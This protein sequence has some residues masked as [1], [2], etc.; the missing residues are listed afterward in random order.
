MDKATSNPFLY[1]PDYWHARGKSMRDLAVH[2]DDIQAKAMMMRIADD[3]DAIARRLEGLISGAPPP[4]LE[5]VVEDM[6]KE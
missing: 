4:A 5:S 6:K 2:M 1:D 3:D